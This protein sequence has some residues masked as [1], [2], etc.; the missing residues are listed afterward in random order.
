MAI[1]FIICGDA[2][3]ERIGRGEQT[4]RLEKNIPIHLTYFTT[5]VDETGRLQQR[6]DLYGH[7]RR[8]RAALGLDG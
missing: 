2:D 4:V 6:D 3:D 5:F 8:V 1:E 7:N